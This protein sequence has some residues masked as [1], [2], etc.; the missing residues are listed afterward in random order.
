MRA[1]A[2]V[3]LCLASLLCL[4]PTTAHA[5]PVR[6]VDIGIDGDA[7]TVWY[8]TGLDRRVPVALLLPGAN[9]HKQYYSGFASALADYGFVVVVPEHYPLPLPGYA[10]PSEDV[11]NHVV[12]WARAAAADPGSPVGA[13]VDP[14]TLV[15]TGHSYGAAAALYAAADRCQ[16]PFCFGLSYRHPPELR[17]IVGHG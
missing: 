13:I 3:V 2:L 17:A 6:S 15:V 5:A 10:L 9:V 16:P 7:A 8:P 14:G 11:L 12:T 4:P 1:L